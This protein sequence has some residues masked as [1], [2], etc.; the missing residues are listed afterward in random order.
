MK[1]QLIKHA[2]SRAVVERAVIEATESPTIR[3]DYCNELVLHEIALAALTA[4]PV[5]YINRN[6]GVFHKPESMPVNTLDTA[7]YFPVFGAH[8]VVAAEPAP[9]E[10]LTSPITDSE[11]SRLIWGLKAAGNN[12]RQV[13]A[14][15]ELQ[16]RRISGPQKM[17]WVNGCSKTVPAALRYLAENERPS[18]GESTFNT[19]HLYQL[20]REVEHMVQLSLGCATISEGGA[21]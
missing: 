8:Q 15:V 21:E 1:E 4:V 10:E 20:A 16:Q 9:I 3:R 11:L 18:G 7:L 6:T 12:E 17:Q 5:G 19:A 14:L 2:L 13:A